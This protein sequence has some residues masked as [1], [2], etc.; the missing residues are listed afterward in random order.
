MKRSLH[1]CTRKVDGLYAREG[2]WANG[3]LFQEALPP[4]DDG[5]AVD[6]HLLSDGHVGLSVG[7]GQY[8]PAPQGDLPAATV[9][10]RPQ[11]KEER[12]VPNCCMMDL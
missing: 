10:P 9:T 12:A 6:G 2:I 7:G 11:P 5:L 8:Y 4:Q 1:P 3:T